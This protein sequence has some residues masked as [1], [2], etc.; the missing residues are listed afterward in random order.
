MKLPDGWKET[1]IKDILSVPVQNGYSPVCQENETGRWVL[2]LG[3]LT[4]YSFNESQIK[5]VPLN[6]KI[7]NDFLPQY[8]DILISLSNTLDKVGRTAVF[9]D[10]VQNCFYPDLMMR[11]RIDEKIVIPDFLEKILQSDIGRKYFES[12]A[13]GTSS[14]MV[15]INKAV[16][17]DFNF[18]YP[19][20]SE[21]KAIVD[22]LSVWDSMIEKTEKLIGEKEKL[23]NN[24]QKTLFGSISNNHKILLKIIADITKG[25]QLGKVDML[26]EGKYQIINGCVSASG[27]TDSWNTSEYTITISEGGN[28][29]GFVNFITEKFWAGGHC[30][31]LCVKNTELINKYFLYWFLK[32]NEIEIMKLRVGSGLPNIQRKNLEQLEIPVCSL[33]EQSSI[34]HTL[35]VAQQE[36]DL[37]RQL[38]DKYKLQKQG[39]MQKLLTGQ[40]RIK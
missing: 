33:E 11:F 36:I 26:P 40:W 25:T 16:I 5:A 13:A 23:F 10:Q 17:E 34:V 22:T 6:T 2:S 4:G 8:G 15:K 24:I 29:C 20:I 35:D 12:K 19:S 21:Q 39:L 32:F 30:Y 27:Y 7:N 37:L 18:I 28:S 9:R 3:A 31:T 1:K 14:S 38:S